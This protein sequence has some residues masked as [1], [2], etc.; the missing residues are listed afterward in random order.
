MDK[1]VGVA[2]NT[3]SGA[4]LGVVTGVP[5]P[6]VTAVP[7]LVVSLPTTVAATASR[8]VGAGSNLTIF[9]S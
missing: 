6:E 3:F 5:S 8:F 2:L 9:S 7:S 4:E 1:L